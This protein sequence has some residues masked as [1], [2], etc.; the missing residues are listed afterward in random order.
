MQIRENER[1]LTILMHDAALLSEEIL[2]EGFY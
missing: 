1:S 2:F